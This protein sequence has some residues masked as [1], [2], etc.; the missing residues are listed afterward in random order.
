MSLNLDAESGVKQAG[1]QVNKVMSKLNPQTGVVSN[2]ASKFTSERWAFATGNYVKSIDKMRAG[3][4]EEIVQ[5]AMPY[6]SPLKIRHQVVA[7]HDPEALVS[8]DTEDERAYLVD[9]EWHVLFY[10][11]CFTMVMLFFSRCCLLSRA[12]IENGEIIFKFRRVVLA[13]AS[14]LVLVVFLLSYADLF[15]SSFSFYM[16]PSVALPSRTAKSSSTGCA[17]VTCGLVHVS[18]SL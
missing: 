2:A 4:L 3:S 5:L 10:F 17:S 11:I 15:T 12:P 9:D 6:M 18:F 1:K 14:G 7:T 13:S 16:L 8:E